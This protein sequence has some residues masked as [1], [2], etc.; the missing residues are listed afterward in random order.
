MGCGKERKILMVKYVYS[1]DIWD[2][3]LRRTVHP[4]EVKL[5]T[6]QYIA[7]EYRQH[8][9]HTWNGWDI[10]NIRLFL[11]NYLKY[12][13]LS[14][15]QDVKF[16]EILKVFIKVCFRE[17]SSPVDDI[18]HDILQFEFNWEKNHTYLDP[19]ISDLLQI[20]S[21]NNYVIFIS[22]FYHGA[23]FIW[24]LLEYHN[25]KQYFQNGF[26]SCDLN[27]SKRNGRLFEK[28]SN[29]LGEDYILYQ[30]VGDNIYSDIIM[31]EKYFIKSN[32]YE[33][34]SETLK[35]RAINKLWRTKKIR[36]ILLCVL[37]SYSTRKLVHSG[38]KLLLG[39]LSVRL[40]DIIQHI[41]IRFKSKR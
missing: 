14:V 40:L 24:K 12:S 41:Y 19:G 27:V 38:D 17:Q 21:S 9:S 31:G 34:Q 8:L 28:I 7:S 36:E 23:E 6:S 1:F 30:H 39:Q 37:F 10:Y 35:N 15:E 3:I 22:D 29:I 2:T 20:Q 18:I 26:V 16:I 5:S 11:E 33:C 13:S 25:V 32:F 4:E